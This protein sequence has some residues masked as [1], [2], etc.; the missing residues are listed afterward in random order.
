MVEMS[1]AN[2]F[3]EPIEAIVIFFWKKYGNEGKLITEV[4]GFDEFS[5]SVKKI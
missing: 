2:R 3:E 4:T 1:F 5:F